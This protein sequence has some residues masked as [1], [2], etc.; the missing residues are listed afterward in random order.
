MTTTP[1][2]FSVLRYVH[3]PVTQEFVNIGVALFSKQAR[4]LSARCAAN[5]GR[6]TKTFGKIDGYRFRQATRYI[7]DQLQAVGEQF[8]LSLPFESVPTI[9]KLLARVLPPDD[10]AF[11]FSPSGGGISA[12]LDKTLAELFGQFVEKYSLPESN[13]R[14]DDEVW[15]V[16]REPLE[17]RSVISYLAPKKI[18]TPD[19]EYEFQHSWKNERWH[20]YE[21]VSFDLME[22]TSILD[23]ANRWL[24]RATNLADSKEKFKMY[25]LLGEPKGEGLKNAFLKAQNILHKMPCHPEFVKESEAE[26]FAEELASEISAHTRRSG[27]PR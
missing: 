27:D 18:V 16:Y 7:Q 1:Y 15:K 10:S 6:I 4:F 2:T 8:S 13:Q 20:V 22:S 19:Y 14:D 5:Y 23:K 25:M 24:G 12:D 17:R 21:P 3:D 11:Q 9:E 26:G